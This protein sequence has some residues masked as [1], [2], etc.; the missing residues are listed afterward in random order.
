MT[1]KIYWLE[2]ITPLHVGTGRGVGLID[3]PII[4]E[5]VTGWPLVPGSSVK[6]V[7]RDYFDQ[8]KSKKTGN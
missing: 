2:A 3:L 4:R 7:I 5:K 1:T 8:E 6:G